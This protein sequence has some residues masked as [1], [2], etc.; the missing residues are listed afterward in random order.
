MGG[1]YGNQTGYG[2]GGYGG[3]G[4]Q[5]K[6]ATA[7]L[8]GFY[9][10]QRGFGRGGYGGFGTQSKGADE[11]ITVTQEATT[12][13]AA[14]YRIGD[15]LLI[16]ASSVESDPTTIR[17]STVAG[18]EETEA[19]FRQFDRSGGFQQVSQFGGEFR[20]EPRNNQEPVT[21][22]PPDDDRPAVSPTDVFVQSFSESE[23][24]PTRIEID[25]TFART[26]PRQPATNPQT[27]SAKPV[28]LVTSRGTVALD[29][30]QLSQISSQATTAGPDFSF[31]LR[32]S[33]EQAG[34][35]VDAIATPDAVER[36]DVPDGP[37]IVRDTS[38]GSQSLTLQT[39]G[40]APIPDGEFGVSGWSLRFKSVGD[41]PWRLQVSLSEL[42]SD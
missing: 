12:E 7:P 21:L 17:L 36:R 28:T 3:P 9:G 15:D 11:D 38:G 31:T 32:L 13:L 4:T 22:F 40:V 2:N 14:P 26:Q 27:D 24:S 37:D 23:R 35:L 20:V 25:L 10:D 19:T 42:G 34:R 41:R 29:E 8:D 18:R 33:P 39:P 6:T 1:S 5:S 30:T 16:R